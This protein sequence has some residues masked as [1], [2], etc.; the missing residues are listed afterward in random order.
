VS[1]PP[2]YTPVHIFVSDSATLS[3][4]PG[5]SL[6]IEFNN[7]KQTTDAINANL[8]L[9]QRD[10]GALLNGVVTYDSLS[11]N[12][13]VAGLTPAVPWV[14]GGSYVGGMNVVQSQNLYRC[15][16][17][18][19][20][21]VFA[22]D[23]AAGKWLFI[24]AL[25]GSAVLSVAGR[26]GVVTLGAADVAFTQTGTG[27][28]ATTLNAR[29]L[30]SYEL[31]D[32][33]GVDPTGATDS[34][35]GITAAI[36]A[37]RTNGKTLIVPDGLY[38][39]SGTINWGWSYLKVMA[40]GDNAAF[41]HSGTGEGHLFNGIMNSQEAV[42]C[43]FGGPGR[44]ML[45][46]NPAGG[47]T[48][49]VHL[50]NWHFS[51]MKVALRDAYPRLLFC[52]NTGSVGASAVET[53]FD[54]Q[55]SQNVD[56]VNFVVPAEIG[57]EI[58]QAVACIFERLVVER[59]GTGGSAAVVL[60]GCI[61]NTLR[62]GTIESNYAGGLVEDSAC[63]RNT[64]INFGIED[65]GTSQDWTLNG[66]YP[67]LINC[68]GA[69]STAGSLFNSTGAMLLG[70]T[71]QSLTNHDETLW[72]N[73][74]EFL[75]AFTDTAGHSTVLNPISSIGV[76]AYDN[77]T[78]IPGNK[79]YNTANNN[80]L[81]I[82]SKQVT[83]LSG[84]G[85]VLPTTASP[86]F[87]GTPTAPTAAA[88]TSTTQIAT[89]AFVI[90]QK[91]V[92][93]PLAYAVGGAIGGSVKYAVADHQHPP[94]VSMATGVAT[95]LGVTLGTAGAVVINGSTLGAE[96]ITTTAPTAVSGAGPVAIGSGST[97]NSRMKVSLNGTDYWI[98]VSTSAF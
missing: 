46:G 44:I 89:T 92:S 41:I 3:N 74:T 71:F 12:L 76:T 51:H 91:A 73:S 31:T 84:T 96:V 70:G 75:V 47:T 66:S 56:G 59:C 45:K 20:A 55:I 86:A 6:D 1:Q 53:V 36:L 61:N 13:Q 42:G 52:T 15:L 28:A 23:L 2:T 94:D 82:N 50:D 38:Q 68:D 19:T 80:I 78:S 88:D 81:K 40:P 16:V 83:D 62:N 79:V 67:V 97:I 5:Q 9:I 43:V 85:T 64:Y 8:K 35:A 65:S 30:Q 90:G 87:T 32:F 63:S 77:A 24:S 58:H 21:G 27:T 29:A 10:D 54:V 22:T 4:F 37:A 48:N 17:P 34:F 18:H 39:H 11:P 7:V 69:G 60:N 93:T 33:A 95:A 14:T 49:L 72:S 25:S 57:A 26:T 98:P